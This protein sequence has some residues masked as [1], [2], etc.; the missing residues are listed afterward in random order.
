MGLNEIKPSKTLNVIVWILIIPTLLGEFFKIQHWPG[1]SILIMFGT[2]IFTFFY[3]PL[4]AIESWKTK[5]T[6]RSKLVLLLQ[7]II[8]LLFAIGL[9][10]LI[11]HWPGA[12]FFYII[13]NYILLFIIVPFSLYHLALL[14]KKN[15]IVSHNI[16]LVIY[17]FVHTISALLNS[18]SG[19]I[20]IDTVLQQGVNTEEALRTASSRNKQL[21]GTLYKIGIDKNNDILIRATKLKTA[22]D[23]AIIHIKDLKSHLLVII[24]K[25]PKTQADTL[26][27]LFIENK[28]N[29]DLTTKILIGNE[30]NLNKDK[31]SASK[32]KSVL[33]NFRDT[34][35]SLIQEQNRTIIQE[36]LNLSTDNYSGEEGQPVSWE[37][38]NFNYMPLLYVFNTLTNIQ[39]EIK[40]AEYQALTDIIN[41]G[42]KDLNTALFSQI[43]N[44]NSKYDAVKKQEEIVKL[45]SENEKGMELLN[46]KDSELSDNKQT[47]VYFILI[48]MVFLMLVFFVLRS[49]YLRKQI[50]NTLLK[51]KEIIESQKTEV[52]DQKNLVEEK[53]KEILDSISYAQRIQNALLPPLAEVSS[54]LPNSFILFKPKDI[55]AG[56][57]YWF[58]ERDNTILIAACDCTGHG[59]PGAFM[60]TIGSE[61]LNEAIKDSSDVSVILNL[62][63]RGM[64]KVLRQTD[65]IN[66]TRDGMDVSL[67]AFNKELT[68]LEYAGAN[69]PL[70]II[71]KDQHEIEEF[72]ATKVAIGGLTEDSQEFVKHSINLQKGDTIYLFSDGYAD[73]FSPQDKKLMTRK[74]K[75]ILLSI[76]NKTMEEQKEYLGSFID[77]WKGNMEQTDDILVIGVRV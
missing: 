22:A 2:F 41:S 61:K 30:Y 50:N 17:F 19:R 67:C 42:N 1:A 14:R 46:A 8:L 36:G 5:E 44:L 35:L 43:T 75:D 37:I 21:Y 12:G 52:E 66:S 6:K 27:S 26:S 38:T 56:D 68:Q 31:Y 62:V 29:L 20:N 11:M 74:F 54:A 65:K 9:T 48:I 18:G 28:V 70:L 4:F 58:S 25:I 71:R 76:Q 47:I 55:V 39:Y 16:L 73:Q 24:D 77:E 53:Q 45:K 23:S 51:Q 32:L 49:N 10:F 63:N 13:N 60:S 57:F 72:K 64:K 15:L 59:V 33:N 40:N 34:L 7:T 3:M 69:R